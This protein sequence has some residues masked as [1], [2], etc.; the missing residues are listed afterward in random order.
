VKNG[1][2]VKD[3]VRAAGWE[4]IIIIKGRFDD[5]VRREICFT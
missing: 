4:K 5:R 2:L 3:A 1:C